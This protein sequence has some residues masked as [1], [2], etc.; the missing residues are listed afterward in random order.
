MMPAITI[1]GCWAP[2]FMR[3]GGGENPRPRNKSDL[4]QAVGCRAVHSTGGLAN[5]TLDPLNGAKRVK[6]I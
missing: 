1:L 6:V 4:L 3:G 5:V 2:V